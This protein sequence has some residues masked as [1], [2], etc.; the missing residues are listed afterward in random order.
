MPTAYPTAIDPVPDAPPGNVP[1]GGSAPKHTEVHQ[2]IADILNALQ[3]MVGLDWVTVTASTTLVSGVPYFI[4]ASGAA[5][6]LTLPASPV[7]GRSRVRLLVIDATNPITVLRNGSKLLGL[8]EDRTLTRAGDGIDLVFTGAAFGWSPA[9]ELSTNH[10][11]LPMTA[12]DLAFTPTADIDAEETHAAVVEVRAD[13]MAAVADAVGQAFD[14]SV[15]NA[16]IFG[17]G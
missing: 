15:V 7:A 6:D 12:A 1:L 11:P 16:L 14:D 3:S 8:S 17:G 10:Q 5:I 13:A 4:D 2:K 9:N